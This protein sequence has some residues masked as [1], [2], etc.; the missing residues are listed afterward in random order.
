MTE[1]DRFSS[2]CLRV[3]DLIVAWAKPAVVRLAERV[4]EEAVA[5]S[6]KA[7]YRFRGEADDFF[8][9]QTVVGLGDGATVVAVAIETRTA[10]KV[11]RAVCLG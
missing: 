7:R 11:F 4:V 3:V 5:Y 9:S 8:F 10:A 1:G 6:P 2:P